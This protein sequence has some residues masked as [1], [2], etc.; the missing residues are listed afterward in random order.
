MFLL[1][2]RVFGLYCLL[3][4]MGDPLHFRKEEY[5]A[6]GTQT[7]RNILVFMELPRALHKEELLMDIREALQK[8]VAET[9]VK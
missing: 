8:T 2:R 4:A 5:F 3:H 1:T 9:S 7:R 6:P